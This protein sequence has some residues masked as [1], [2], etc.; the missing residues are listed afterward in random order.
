MLRVEK[1]LPLDCEDKA[2]KFN[3]GVK[4]LI[5][6]IANTSVKVGCKIGAGS[7]YKTISGLVPI[8]EAGPFSLEH[9]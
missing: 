3:E 7:M 4:S 5:E 2:A 6:G 1:E 9:K 8:K